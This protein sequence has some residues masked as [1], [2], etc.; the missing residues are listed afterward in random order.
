M[1]FAVTRGRNAQGNLTDEAKAWAVALGREYIPRLK[2]E[3]LEELL[4]K[5]NLDALLLAT[6]NGPQIYNREGILRFHPGMAVLRLENLCKGL[7]D[8]FTT[9]CALQPGEKF[10][11]CT[12]GL[13]GDSA[14]AAYLVGETGK[15]VG[16]E[17]SQPLWFLV[18]Q[19]LEHYQC[20]N[21][22]L[23]K[24]LRRIT[25]L[26]VKAEEYLVTLP[27]DSFSVL[28]FDPMFR[29]P[30]KA[31]SN[32]VPLRPVAYTMPLTKEVLKEALQVAPKV[33]IKEHTEK[34][35]SELGCEEIVGG[36]YSHVKYGILRR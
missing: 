10:L 9:A 19:G 21:P 2:N 14:I 17:A 1:K 26:N 34:V 13:G 6:Q 3:S 28:Y 20:E 33:V 36:K 5:Y 24:A 7:K 11:D 25:A 18:K 23:T 22:L 4:A 8:N 30:I 31:S 29:H 32:M 12:L 15:V 16:L 35:L 27:A